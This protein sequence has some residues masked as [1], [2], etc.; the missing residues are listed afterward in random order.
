[1]D[2]QEIEKLARLE[3]EADL[4]IEKDIPTVEAPP[5]P[6]IIPISD[7]DDSTRVRK[8]YGE[9]ESLKISIRDFRL[10][11][12][13]VLTWDNTRWKLLAGGRRLAAIR[14]L[15]WKELRHIEH[16]VLREDLADSKNLE[17]QYIRQ[18][19][20]YEENIRRKNMEWT[21]EVTAKA[22]LLALMQ[23]RFGVKEGGGTSR[24]ERAGTATVEQTGFS[25][26]KL[27]EQLGESPAQ[28][29]NDIQLAKFLEHVPALAQMETKTAALRKIQTLLNV[30]MMKQQAV[31]ES[32]KE[33]PYRLYR[34]DVIVNVRDLEDNSVD[35]IVTDLPFGVGLD[36]MSRHASGVIDYSDSRDEIIDLINDLIPQAFRIL[37]EDRFAVFFFGFN[38]YPHLVDVLQSAGFKVNLVPFIW[39]K[40]TG[41]TENPNTRYANSYDAALVCSKGTP[42]FVRPGQR[43]FLQASPEANKLQ[44]AQ[45]PVAV[46]ERFILDM[47]GP[48]ATIV[49][50]TAG[51]G[52]TGEAALLH[53]R[54]PILFEE[55]ENL[56]DY[57]TGRLD[58]FAKKQSGTS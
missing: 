12:P 8:D 42:M 29:S 37:R 46:P 25:L 47:T 56:C 4:E 31:P 52:T 5:C 38:Y 11:Q 28:T 51:T 54:Y 41:S 13:I 14:A 17:V 33:K 18:A 53:D 6:E 10:I 58:G 55:D 3:V 45:Q 39:Y 19:I 36:K 1:V 32:E 21:E 40:A 16:F 35:L 15:G 26:R 27:S 22:K 24:A 48:K 34:G 23:K 7:I 43:N 20:E 49:D 44:I 9:L 50:L 30:A 2:Q 57:I